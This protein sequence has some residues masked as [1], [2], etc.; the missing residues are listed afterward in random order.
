MNIIRELRP[1]GM[2]ML[3]QG[4]YRKADDGYTEMKLS[5]VRVYPINDSG[6][7]LPALTMDTSK[8]IIFTAAYRLAK[9]ISD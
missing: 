1:N 8:E 3:I 9:L 2:P 5:S 4:E 7:V 6:E